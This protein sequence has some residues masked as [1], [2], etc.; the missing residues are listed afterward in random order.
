M[1]G[2]NWFFFLSLFII[3]IYPAAGAQRYVLMFP[4]YT[5]IKCWPMVAES[6][7]AI[8]SLDLLFY[9]QIVETL[10]LLHFTEQVTFVCFVLSEQMIFFSFC[11][12]RLWRPCLSSTLVNRWHLFACK[13]AEA[14][15]FLHFSEQITFVCFSFSDCGGLVF[16]APLWTDA[17]RERVSSQYCCQQAGD[18][19][20]HGPRLRRKTLWGQGGQIRLGD[21]WACS[22][23]ALGLA[24]WLV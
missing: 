14:M 16:P 4:P 18:V 8:R 21:F 11:T 23:L 2:W 22:E 12:F 3:G 17:S 9:F 19:E 24:V 6:A 7:T 15:S 5:K 20:T 10:S 1:D 13:I